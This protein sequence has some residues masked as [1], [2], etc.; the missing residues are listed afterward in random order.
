M[1]QSF[2]IGFSINFAYKKREDFYYLSM[3]IILDFIKLK[4][5]P[6]YKI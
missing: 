4:L 3:I 1:S 2:D 6:V 5:R